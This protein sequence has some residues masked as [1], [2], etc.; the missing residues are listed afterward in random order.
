MALNS[1]FVNTVVLLFI[2]HEIRTMVHGVFIIMG[3][4]GKHVYSY[5]DVNETDTLT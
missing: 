3:I 2:D 1:V 5:I 4:V